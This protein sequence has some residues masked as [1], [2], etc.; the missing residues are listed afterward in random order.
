MRLWHYQLI[1]RLPQKQLCGQWRECIALLGNGWGKKH[2]TVDY[3]FNHPDSHL[4]R[5]AISIYQEMKNRG[6]NADFT[7]IH[8]AL[9]KRMTPKLAL[10][11]L[12][13]ADKNGTRYK[14]H[15]E[16]YLKECIENLK[17]KGVEI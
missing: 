3:V 13:Q 7:L 9:T 6:Y 14:E 2:K 4:I 15:N 8:K 1:P 17:E 10:Y 16:E 12:F 5:Y 11:W